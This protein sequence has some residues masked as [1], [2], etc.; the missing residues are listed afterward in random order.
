MKIE[1]LKIKSLEIINWILGKMTNFTNLNEYIYIKHKDILYHLFA[2]LT[3]GR[4]KVLFR[5]LIHEKFP[6]V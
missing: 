3:N 4:E 2:E 6:G 5:N 1:L